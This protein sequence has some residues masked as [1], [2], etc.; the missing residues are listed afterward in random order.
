MRNWSPMDEQDIFER[1]MAM[2]RQ[3]NQKG[4]DAVENQ[5][6]LH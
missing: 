1:K 6:V 5:P 2:D 3:Q 4:N